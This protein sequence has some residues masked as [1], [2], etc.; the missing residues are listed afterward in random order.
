MTNRRSAAAFLA[1]ATLAAHPAAARPSEPAPA[2]APRSAFDQGPGPGGI[3][4]TWVTPQATGHTEK[5]PVVVVG[6]NPLKVGTVDPNSLIRGVFKVRNESDQPLKVA[7]IFAGCRCTFA[8]MDA[9]V[10]PPHT[11]VLMHFEIDLRGSV[12]EVLKP[13]D[14]Y[15]EGN[16]SP[17][18]CTVSGQMQYPI[19]I[20]APYVVHPDAQTHVGQVTLKSGDG[21]PFAVTAVNGVA[22]HIIASDPPN[23]QR[24]LSLTLQFDESSDHPAL[25][26]LETTHPGAPVMEI[27]NYDNTATSA[28]LPY[29]KTMNEIAIGRKGCNIGV[30][31]KD[32]AFEFETSFYRKDATQEVK[33]WG[34][35]PDVKFE[36]VGNYPAR[37]PDE[38]GLRIRVTRTSDRSGY[39][40]TPVYVSNGELK[41]RM[42]VD[43]LL[44]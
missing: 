33:V 16:D 4:S 28:E 22:P 8:W 42:W 21:V 38:I 23:A 26:V 32:G 27:K 18:R 44:K 41:T 31:P 43:G 20:E 39:L 30:L 10:L 12:G 7:A 1:L 15:L 37:R 3:K 19:H 2:D 9:D 29:L 40:L 14:I 25:Y 36:L 11:P 5:P 17:A 13:I 34:E 24:A 6:T 35:S